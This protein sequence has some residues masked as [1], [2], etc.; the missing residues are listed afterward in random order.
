MVA[1]CLRD[2]QTYERKKVYE[3]KVLWQPVFEPDGSALSGIGDA[4]IK[5]QQAFPDYVTSEK[6]KELTGI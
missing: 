6:L 4:M 2:N 3:T 1:A 5:L